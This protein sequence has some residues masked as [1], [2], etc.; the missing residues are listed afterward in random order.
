MTWQIRLALSARQD[1]QDAL[2]VTLERF[3]RRQH[4]LYASLIAQAVSEIGSDPFG[5]RST[6]RPELHANAR[7]L[8]IGRRGKRA[9]HFFV[10][11]VND[12]SSIDIARFLHDA[13]ELTRHLPDDL[14]AG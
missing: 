14:R 1:I 13:M 3:G 5:N 12:N 11:R 10:Y 4:D 2:G 9:R 6:S 8:H 7:T